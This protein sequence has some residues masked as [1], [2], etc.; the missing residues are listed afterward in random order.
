VPTVTDI[1]DHGQLRRFAKRTAAVATRPTLAYMK[2]LRGAGLEMDTGYY[3]LW[4]LSK[5][6]HR[7]GHA[8]VAQFVRRWLRLMYTCD[9]PPEI[10][11]D[12]R[13]ALVPPNTP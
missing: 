9:L 7:N 2:Q 8:H 10:E 12:F 5:C 11:M 4:Q 1:H 13:V 6:L 3:R